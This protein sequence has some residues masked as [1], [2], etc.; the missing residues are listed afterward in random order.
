MK[1]FEMSQWVDYVRGLTPPSDAVVMARHLSDGCERCAALMGLVSRIR[2]EAVAETE[3]PERLVSTAKSLFPSKLS[4]AKTIPWLS[5]PRLAARR[6][7]DSTAGLALE[8][9]RTTLD[10]TVQLVY[11]A[12][13]Y[14]IELQIEQEP[15][16][17]RLAVIGQ[18]LDRAG[19]GKPLSGAPVA[20]TARNQ[21]LAQG[22]TSRFGEFCLVS[23]ARVGLTVSMHIESIGKRVQI[24]LNRIMAGR[25]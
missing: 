25:G 18:V 19:G 1:H 23:R 7:F 20:L 12:G 9:A 17:T 2:E 24:P 11:H 16:S 10:S 13:D 8:G 6:V 22:A 14:A 3:A 15:E 21:L 4:H 5:L